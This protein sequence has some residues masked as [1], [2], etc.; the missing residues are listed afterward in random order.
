MQDPGNLRSVLWLSE[1][2]GGKGVIL[3][4]KT[5]DPYNPTSVRAGMGAIFTQCICC[6]RT[7]DSAEWKFESDNHIVGAFTENAANDRKYNYSR[8]MILM[9]GSE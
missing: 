9:M 8:D 7:E 5:T 6:A 2:A 3:V 4:D 1:D